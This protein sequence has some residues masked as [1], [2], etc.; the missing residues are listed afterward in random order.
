[1][2]DHGW[3]LLGRGILSIVGADPSRVAVSGIFTGLRRWYPRRHGVT[4]GA[5]PPSFVLSDPSNSNRS[6][7]PTGGCPTKV[8]SE[9]YG[10]AKLISKI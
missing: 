3:L 9:C 6:S 1:M 8:M 7:S 10:V 5:A 2:D 4:Y